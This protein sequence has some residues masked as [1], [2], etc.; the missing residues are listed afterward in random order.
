MDRL[1]FS[2]KL[3]REAGKLAHTAFGQSA[4]SMKG[5][6]DVLTAMD[7]EVEHYIRAAITARYPFATVRVLALI[8][9]H[10]LGLKLA[11]LPVHHHPRAGQA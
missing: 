4:T 2:G 5:R 11:G 1:E 6:H 9:A 7:G 10:A 8:Y 3:A